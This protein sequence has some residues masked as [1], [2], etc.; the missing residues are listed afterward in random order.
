[1]TNREHNWSNN[2][3][4][5]LAVILQN[6]HS[7]H[8]TLN[9][10][11]Q[12][13]LILQSEL[14][15]IQIQTVIETWKP[16]NFLPLEESKQMCFLFSWMCLTTL[17]SNKQ[18]KRSMVFFN[19]PHHWHFSLVT[20]KN[21]MVSNYFCLGFLVFVCFSCCKGWGG[22]CC[23]VFSNETFQP[24]TPIPHWRSQVGFGEHPP[25]QQPRRAH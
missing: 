5:I 19:I 6:M 21:H 8:S 1:M 23:E 4:N 7:L 20:S 14:N 9:C 2:F 15:G 18:E 11:M 17:S 22:S 12:R 3:L 13:E 16:L 25:R 24:E 10:K